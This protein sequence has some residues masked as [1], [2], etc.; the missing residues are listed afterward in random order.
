MS[1]SLYNELRPPLRANAELFSTYTW[2]VWYDH[3]KRGARAIHTAHPDILIFLSGLGGDTDLRPVV[4]G[5]ALAPSRSPFRQRDFAAGLAA[6]LVLE[7]H[8]YD[9]VTPVSDCPRYNGALLAS[10]YAA[11]VGEPAAHSRFPVVLSEW[12]FP[13][14]GTTW[15]NGTYA[16]CVQTF[17]REV[18]PGQGWFVWTLGGSYYL[19]EGA[20]DSD[21][22]W[23]LLNHDWS[24]WRSPGFVEGGLKPLVSSTLGR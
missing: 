11:A 7:L 12:G 18:V 21:E 4:D 9:I 24:G 19:R 23:G 10:G 15:W 5:T 8:S 1:M 22:P 3:V 14:D 16:R 17:L 6:K 2:E 13:Q 20:Q